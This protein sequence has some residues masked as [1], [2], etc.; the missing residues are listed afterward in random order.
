MLRELID[1][2]V[3]KSDLVILKCSNLYFHLSNNPTYRNL[4]GAHN[5]G[6]VRGCVRMFI[7][8]SYD[9]Q[10]MKCPAIDY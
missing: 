4:S 3:L 10:Q 1:A 5:N 2:V 9:S 6:N 7:I 8:D